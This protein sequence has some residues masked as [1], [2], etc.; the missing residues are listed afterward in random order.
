MQYFE[1]IY[2]LKYYLA[3]I[4]AQKRGWKYDLLYKF[5]PI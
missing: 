5:A 1:V 4:T 2:F 3:E